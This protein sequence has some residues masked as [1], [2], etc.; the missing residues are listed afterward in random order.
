LKGVFETAEKQNK[1]LK[2]RDA[3][4]SFKYPGKAFVSEAATLT[5]KLISLK[6]NTPRIR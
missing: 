2:A 6:F 1:S 3:A 5:S 4:L